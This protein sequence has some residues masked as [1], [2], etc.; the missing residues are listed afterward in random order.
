MEKISEVVDIAYGEA[1]LENVELSGEVAEQFPTVFSA[2]TEA[3]GKM[4]GVEGSEALVVADEKKV[5]AKVAGVSA[6]VESEKQAGREWQVVV[7]PTGASIE[8]AKAMTREEDHF[9]EAWF[10]K[11]EE[12]GVK[13]F[14]EKTE[15]GFAVAALPVETNLKRGDVAAQKAEIGQRRAVGEKLV[16]PNLMMGYMY[17]DAREKDGKD[18]SMFFRMVESA[19][20]RGGIGYG[21]VPFMNVF[22]GTYSFV[23]GDWVERELGGRAAVA[24]A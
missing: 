12:E 13:P 1:E 23:D 9:N 6:F 16:A 11:C 17:R 7:Y 2:Y 19:P 5:R 8:Q 14:G 18:P 20:V 3:V 15:D 24:E 22:G 10:R 21:Q 4:N